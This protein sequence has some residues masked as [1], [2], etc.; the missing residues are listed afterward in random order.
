MRLFSKI[1]LAVGLL[2]APSLFA[3]EAYLTG[4]PDYAWF[5]GCFGTATGNLM[6]YWDRH[7]LPDFY[8]GPTGGGLAPFNDAGANVGIRSMWASK[9]GLDGRPTNKPG[10]IDDYWSFYANDFSFSYESTVPDPYVTAGRAEHQ[11]DCVGDFIGLS[12]KK[13][14]NLNSECDGNIDAYSFV[15]WDLKGNARTNFVPPSV[16]GSPARDIQSGLREWTQWRGYDAEVFTQLAETSVNPNTPA[17]KGFTYENIKR[18]INAGYPLLVFL[19]PTNQYSR[20]LAGMPRGNPEI[21]GMMIY[22]YADYPEFGIRSMYMR[23]SWGS[24]DGQIYRWDSGFWIGDLSVRGVI[25]FHP[26]PRV[27]K[28]S[29]DTTSV[30]LQWDGPSSLL[31][32]AEAQTTTPVHHYQIQRSPNMRPGTWSNVGTPTTDLNATVEDTG[33]TMAFYRVQ[34]L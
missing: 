13:W 32:D 15:Y 12:Q 3:A 34:L 16:A 7:G 33:T 14:T 2:C 11:P 26:K 10:H 28:V 17:G 6:G 21:H 20:S 23:T 29:R 8:T 22:G 18:E 24:G 31:Y 30:S 1:V 27:R 19:Q 5:A 4:T 9:A 25:G